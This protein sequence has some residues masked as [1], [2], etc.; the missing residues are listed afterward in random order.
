MKTSVYF[1]SSFQVKRQ[2]IQLKNKALHTHLILEILT[3]SAR[4]TQKNRINQVTM[5]SFS[6]KNP[7]EI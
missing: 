1:V 4:V 3:N 2:Q 5:F 6:Y 7:F